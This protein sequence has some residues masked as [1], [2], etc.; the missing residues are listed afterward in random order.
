[1]LE[2]TLSRSPL[3]TVAFA[4]AGVWAFL[5]LGCMQATVLEYGPLV[6]SLDGKSELSI[7]TYPAGFPRETSSVPFLYKALRT[8][9]SVYFQVF[10]RGVDKKSGP[11]PHI[12][13]IRIHSFSYQFPG[14]EPVE[15]LS[16][17]DGN[18][19]MQGNPQ[20]D[21]GESAPVPHNEHWYLQLKVDLT[22]NGQNYQFDERVDAAAR[23]NSLPLL[24][25]AL[26]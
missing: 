3:R 19:W 6:R 18:F 13:S 7:S 4:M 22:V 12:D 25:H 11:N 24:F 8:P 5:S 23:R 26:Q 16:D 21:P 10:V 9:E 1:M 15:L 14:Q 2:A 17:F 20:Y